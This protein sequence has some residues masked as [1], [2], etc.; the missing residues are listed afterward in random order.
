MIPVQV[1]EVDPGLSAGVDLASGVDQALA[2]YRG[3]KLRMQAVAATRDDEDAACTVEYHVGGR[4]IVA[5]YNERPEPELGD[6]GPA[7]HLAQVL[8]VL[9]ENYGPAERILSM[10][11][12]YVTIVP[13]GED[14]EAFMDT[15]LTAVGIDRAGV[16]WGST[17]TY[18]RDVDGTLVFR[19]PIT[20][21]AHPGGRIERVLAG[22]AEELRRTN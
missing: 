6:D 3:A 21:P 17:I 8:N 15:G 13:E 19:E 20:G 9:L 1:L 5:L 16:A 22:F 14:D 7:F 4:T 2:R 10:H 18:F 12:T 11:E